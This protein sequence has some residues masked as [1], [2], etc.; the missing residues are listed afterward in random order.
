ME[1]NHNQEKVVIF[2][3]LTI[4]FDVKYGSPFDLP[5]NI[6]TLTKNVNKKM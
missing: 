1:N 5:E 6:R 2:W 4:V 3:L